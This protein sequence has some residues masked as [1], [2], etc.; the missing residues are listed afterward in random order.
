[1][2]LQ[3]IAAVPEFNPMINRPGQVTPAQYQDIAR[4]HFTS[5]FEESLGRIS[6]VEAE[7]AILDGDPAT[8]L[9]EQ[10]IDLDLLV[11]GSR[12]YGP[13]RRV[14]LGGVSGRVIELA[15]CPVIVVPRG[16]DRLSMRNSPVSSA[17]TT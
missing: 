17:R 11:V 4:K 1:M 12:G 7:T 10:G 16:A 8:V 2:R 9:A 14:F 3:L 15:P 13:L 5:A 6:D